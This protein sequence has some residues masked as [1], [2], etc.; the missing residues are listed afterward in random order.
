M[1]PIFLETYLWYQVLTNH[2]H[3]LAYVCEHRTSKTLKP[4]GPT[5]ERKNLITWVL[6]TKFVNGS[7][8]VLLIQGK[9]HVSK[10]TNSVI[11]LHHWS[12]Q[13]FYSDKYVHGHGVKSPFIQAILQI[14]NIFTL[15]IKCQIKPKKYKVGLSETR[16]NSNKKI[17]QLLNFLAWRA[18]LRSKRAR[19]RD[20][21]VL[22][23]S[24]KKK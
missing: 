23:T 22:G 20:D 19:E 9:L 5:C 15:C 17:L 18:A 13:R 16:F 1:K 8:H 10:I 12:L 3:T 21:I 6:K 7:K 4:W 2:S 24:A 11:H 14:L